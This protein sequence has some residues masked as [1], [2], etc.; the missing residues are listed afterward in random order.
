MMKCNNFTFIYYS[1][2]A[3]D[4]S[5]APPVFFYVNPLKPELLN[6]WQKIIF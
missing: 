2:Y 1:A 5:S 3:I 4:M 6:N